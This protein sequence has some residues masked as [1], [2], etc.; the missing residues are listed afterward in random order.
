MS[1]A[2]VEKDQCDV[3]ICSRHGKSCSCERR[4]SA[5][6]RKKQ[7]LLQEGISVLAKSFTCDRGHLFKPNSGDAGVVF[8]ARK[9]QP[10]V[11]IHT[12]RFVGWTKMRFV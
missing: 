12:P 4:G 3:P 6:G 1:C 8:Y 7:G 5:K 11:C 9:S 10:T 2:F